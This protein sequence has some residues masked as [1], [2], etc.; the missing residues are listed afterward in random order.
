MKSIGKTIIVGLGF[1]ALLAQADD[2]AGDNYIS[3]MGSAIKTDSDRK[4]DDGIEGGVA[5]IGGII[6][7]N[8]NAEFEVG[9]LNLDWDQPGGRSTDQIY[10]GINALNVYNRDGSFQ[11]FF[12]GGLGMVSNEVAGP[13]RDD[14]NLYTNLG[15]GAF[16]PIFDDSVK[17]RG[18]AIYRWENASSNYTDIILNLGVSI[19]FGKERAAPAP[20]VAA[21]PPPPADSD[22]DGVFDDA[23]R[24]PNTPPG[25]KVDQYGCELDSDRDGVVDSKDKC[26]N[27]PAGAKV[28]ATGCQIIIRLEGVNFR[29]NSDQLQDGAEAALEDDAQALIANPE[30]R[31]EVAGHTDSSGDA[32]YNMDLSKRRAAT[33]EKYLESK[34]IAPD[35]ITSRGYGEEKPI[36]DNSTTEGRRANRRV[37]LRLLN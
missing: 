11:P 12:L 14:T 10:V 8:W 37:E 7:D 20:V 36:A 16:V 6:N 1:A 19:P 3:L 23:D 9:T 15:V 30:R 18:E 25:V 13:T 24:C 21:V 35:R 4:L 26:P 29:L 31:V 17:L 27:T 5:K 32:D 22:G 28:D 2:Q 33:V 34:G